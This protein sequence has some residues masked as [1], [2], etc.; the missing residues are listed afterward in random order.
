MSKEKELA[1]EIERCLNEAGKAISAS[2]NG[3]GWVDGTRVSIESVE[4]YV[5]VIEVNDYTSPD[6]S[7]VE[8]HK[9]EYTVR[10]KETVS[11]THSKYVV[12]Y[13]DLK[14]RKV[15]LT[16]LITMSVLDRTI[17]ADTYAKFTYKV[18]Q[19]IVNGSFIRKQDGSIV[20]IPDETDKSVQ[21]G[22]VE[23]TTYITTET[24]R[25]TIF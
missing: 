21:S 9:T 14:E 4:A 3:N 7:I 15:L 10:N 18:F 5:D 2:I 17:D 11:K 12:S 8:T 19:N 1:H 16:I 6:E 23:V 13:F 20:K 25:R 22:E 24:V